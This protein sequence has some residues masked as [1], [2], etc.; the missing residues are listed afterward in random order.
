M[1]HACS[2][3][4]DIKVVIN[5]NTNKQMSRIWT[6]TH[7]G[8]TWISYMYMHRKIMNALGAKHIEP[9]LGLSYTGTWFVMQS[10]LCVSN[11]AKLWNGQ[12]WRIKEIVTMK[13]CTLKSGVKWMSLSTPVEVH[14][15]NTK[16]IYMYPSLVA[17]LCR[18]WPKFVDYEPW[19]VWPL[20]ID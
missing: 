8:I 14:V 2:G 7:P 3:W 19:I 4:C 17:K 13:P 16:Y 12:M 15:I 18:Y 1:T 9:L 10:S 20:A 5:T 6:M 11:F